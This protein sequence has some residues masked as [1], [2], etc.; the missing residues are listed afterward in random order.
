MASLLSSFTF[1]CAHI[2]FSCAPRERGLST[3]P[4][5]QEHPS[6]TAKSKGSELWLRACSQKH[7]TSPKD[8]G[9]YSRHEIHMR[10]P[11]SA[12]ASLLPCTSVWVRLSNIRREQKSLQA[13]GGKTRP[14]EE[15]AS[16]GKAYAEQKPRKA[17]FSAHASRI[18]SS[19]SRAL[20][21]PRAI[22]FPHTPW[23]ACTSK[24]GP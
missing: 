13:R 7:A 8:L 19:L 23:T 21:V 3:V 24:G 1:P 18:S 15:S 10:K 17:K 22:L 16:P 11:I 14:L 20:V 4:V 9:T 2:F 12:H 6:S 5:P